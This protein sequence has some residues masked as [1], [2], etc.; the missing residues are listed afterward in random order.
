M[1]SNETT[2]SSDADQSETSQPVTE[3]VVEASGAE[4]V[5]SALQEEIALLKQQLTEQT[6]KADNFK[7]Q[8]VRIAADFD[9]FRKR[10]S[11]DKEMLEHQV[12][13]NTITELL[14]VIDNF[15]RARTQIKPSTEGEKG[16]HKSYQGVYKIL[17]DTL[18]RIGVS[19][20]RPEGQPF[21]PNFH[22]AMLREPTD[23]YPEGTVIEELMRGYLLEDQVLRHAMV[24]VAA[25]KETDQLTE[26]SAEN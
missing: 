26:T 8:Y 25:P 14:P 10:S 6:E 1:N 17:V 23:E 24:K 2:I 12:K 9:N 19:P 20:M 7:G 13:R 11:K 22:E 15:E 18:K 5:I 16:I 21:D 3:K 4:Q